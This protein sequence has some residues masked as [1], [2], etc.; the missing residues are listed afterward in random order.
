[1]NKIGMAREKNCGSIEINSFVIDRFESQR[2][3]DSKIKRKEN[4]GHK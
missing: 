1:M 4:M 2:G 3:I